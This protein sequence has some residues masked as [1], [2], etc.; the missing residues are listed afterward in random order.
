M[1]AAPTKRYLPPTALHA[2]PLRAAL[3]AGVE[4]PAEVPCPVTD[5][6]VRQLGLQAQ[7]VG[8]RI[9]T[10]FLD[11]TVV[12]SADEA[13]L[14]DG[15]VLALSAALPGLVGA[16]LRKG[17]YY[18]AMRAGI[19]HGA[20]EAAGVQTPG[21]VTLKLFNLIADEVAPAVLARGL[22]LGRDRA[23]AL[24]HDLGEPPHHE[25]GAV[26]LTLAQEPLA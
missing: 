12:D 11:G 14:R 4:V 8:R 21:L 9:S 20:D 16:T 22:V 18:A 3:Q 6:L 5:F 10:I 23:V 24:L 25:S 15:S 1:L 13:V 26:L 19:T 17:G 7:Y 2:S